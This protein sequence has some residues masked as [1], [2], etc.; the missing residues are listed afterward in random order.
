MGPATPT[1]VI[2]RDGVVVASCMSVR[3]NDEA[4]ECYTFTEPAFRR[5]GWGQR[6]TAAWGRAVLQ[7]GKIAFY[8]YAQDNRASQV[9][10]KSLELVRRFRLVTYE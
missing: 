10:A 2:R 1:F 3:E 9:L 4:A 5:Q 7:N 8:N 6:V